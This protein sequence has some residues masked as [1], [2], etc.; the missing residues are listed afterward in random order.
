[1]QRI[2]GRIQTQVEKSQREYY[3]TEQM[4]A[5]Q[6]E[7]GRED[8]ALEIEALRDKA[9]R[10]GLSKEAQEKVDKELRRLEQMPPLSSEAVVSRNYV[11]WM[12]SIPWKK[13]TKDTIGLAQAE[14]ILDEN[15][16][17]L[18]KV[19]ERIIEFLAAKKF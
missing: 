16:A 19:K 4:K 9:K 18:K 11:D 2:Q 7:L 14:K 13:V 8:Q 1:E 3:L 15:H 17:G 6:K 10:A 5:I 12:L